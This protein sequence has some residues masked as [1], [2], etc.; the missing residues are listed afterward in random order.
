MRKSMALI[1]LLGL[2]L[3]VLAQKDKDIPAF[4]TVEKADLQ[5]KECDFDKDAE[6]VVLFDVG[7]AYLD[8]MYSLEL[9][10]HIRI[11]ILKDKGLKSAD[12]HIPYVSF[13]GQQNI[14]GLTAATYNLDAAGN[15]VTT[16]VE[17]K[18]VYEK[19]IDKRVSE[20]VFTFPEVKAG[21]IIEYKYTRTNI[22]LID[23]YFQ[24]SIPVKYSRYRIDFPEEL[25]FTANPLCVLP[26]EQKDESKGRRNVR[27]ISMKNIPALRD[28]AYITCDDDY[29]QR[30]ETRLIALNFPGVPRRSLISNWPQVIKA[31]VEDED[32]GIQMKRDIPRTADLDASLQKLTDPYQKMV[33]IHQYV[34]KNMEWNNLGNI[35]AL[36]GV[37][38]AWKDKKGTSGEI[39]L[40]LVNL[41]KDA[42]LK[43][44]PLLVSTRG[45]GRVNTSF[46][47]IGNFDKVL[48]Y[49]T[50]GER[51]YVLDA[52]EHYTPSSLIPYEVMYSEG[53]LIE[54]FDT[55]QWGWRVLWDEKPHLRE[56]VI[57]MSE[58]NEAGIMKGNA[59]VTSFDYSRVRRLPT[60]KQGKDKFIER[61]FTENIPGMKIDSLVLQNEEVDSLPLT[62][63]VG[64]NLPVNSSGDYKYFSVNLFTGLEKNPFL[65]D[66]RFSDVFFGTNQNY[67]IVANVTIPESYEFEALPK[68]IRMIMPDTSISITRRVN[69]EKN[70]L[71]VRISLEFSKP[72]YSPEEYPDFKE[73]YKQLFAL[74]N[75]QYAIRKKAKS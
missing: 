24:R 11:K 31:L 13:R 30:V 64:F 71:A 28:E 60:L 5:M 15:I 36:N 62:Q 54:K 44:S 8:N 72:Y 75:E 40:I 10:R 27:A 18:L 45:N 61:Y 50:I 12:I 57:M 37:R 14:K 7:E 35:W 22:A 48:A 29:L 32:F 55:G 52:T 58:I 43:A 69:A 74:L 19:Q 38:A 41:L 33:A 20:Q 70:T 25:E 9:V 49:V 66:T 65:A 34:R 16:K 23:W 2:A 53:L 39:N 73:F 51:V 56:T 6:A 47:D 59:S 3:P 42:G 46:A 68:S 17:K 67:Q 63:N 26:V 21:S 1:A 4:G